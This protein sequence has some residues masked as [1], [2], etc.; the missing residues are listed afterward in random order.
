MNEFPYDNPDAKGYYPKTESVANTKM[1]TLPIAMRGVTNSPRM[2]AQRGVFTLFGQ[3]TESMETCFTKHTF[4]PESLIK[5]VV[6][7]NDIKP[8]MQNVLSVGYTDTVTYPDLHGLAME[9][10]RHFG[11]KV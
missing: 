2:H 8:M 10:K 4:A 9:L 5:I 3:E 7:K 11:F 1:P 6:A